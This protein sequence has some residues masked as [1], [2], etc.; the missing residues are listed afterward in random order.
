MRMKNCLNLSMLLFVTISTLSAQTYDG[1]TFYSKM[2]SN[3][4]YLLNMNNS[5]YHTWTFNV[6]TGYS[7]YLLPN[8]HVMRSCQYSGNQLSGAAMCGEV[9]EVDWAGNVVWQYI[10]STSTYCTHHDIHPMPNGNVLLISY[11]VKSPTEVTQ[12]GCSQNITMWPDKIVEV[13]PNGTNGGTIVWEWHVWDHLCQ[14]VN[15]AKNNYVTSIVEHPELLNINY[16]T[17]KDWMHSNGIDYN[18]TLDQI[19][20]SSHNL[21][22]MYVID[23]STTTAEAAG[24]TGGNSGKGGDILYRWGNPQVYSAGTTSNQIFKVVHDAHWVPYGCPNAADLVGFN[25]QGAPGNHSCIDRVTPPYDGYNYSITLG[26]AYTPPTYTWRHVCLG[27]ANDQSNSQ[28]LPNGNTLICI[29]STGYIY[30]INSSQALLWS[31]TA[32]GTVPKAFRYT[33]CYVNGN[34]GVDATASPSQ[35]CQG[36]SAQLNATL[37]TGTASSYSWTSNPPGFISALQNPTVTPSVTTTYYVTAADGSCSALDSVI[38]TVTNP[39]TITAT[40]TP[41]T[42]CPGQSSQ[43]NAEVSGSTSYT[44]SWTS[45]PPGFTSTLQNPIVS[46]TVT[47]TYNVTASNGSCIATN[48]IPVTVSSPFTIEVSADPEIICYGESSN[49]QVTVSGSSASIGYSWTS[50][51]AGFSSFLQNPIVAPLS[52]TTYTIEVTDGTCSVSASTTVDVVGP[53]SIAAIAV[54]AIICEGASS[55]LSANAL[56]G[57]NYL[58]SWTSYPSGFTSNI[59]NPVVFPTVSTTYYLQV[60]STPCSAQDSVN[61]M[62]NPLPPT[63]VINQS[64]DTLFSSAVTGNQWYRNSGILPGA[65][66]NF[67]IPQQNG[68]YQVQI[69]DENGCTSSL[70][71]EVEVTITSLEEYLNSIR[72]FPNPGSGILHIEGVSSNSDNLTISIFDFKGSRVMYRQFSNAID[73]SAYSNGIYCLVICQDGKLLANRKVILFK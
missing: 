24:H 36:S 52:T 7:S 48:S 38:V 5:I 11:E 72:I 51:P 15:P 31:F 59:Q 18:P 26:S 47:T 69:T 22:E 42:I 17:Q 40:A 27:N 49:L 16:A 65:T 2:G 21:N 71:A 50:D 30:E 39:V 56:G 13:Q 33:A 25:N 67:I 8:H 37:T 70:S 19:V 43:L 29:A 53:L 1:Y 63:P 60:Q 46:P 54:P 28:Q 20:F 41:S 32:G 66:G 44:Y 4:A 58:F 35:V 57:S 62:V 14:N 64:G 68:S 12:A 6:S 3:K 34:L 10:Y 9:Q 55:Q 61:V 45:V 23:H 73:L